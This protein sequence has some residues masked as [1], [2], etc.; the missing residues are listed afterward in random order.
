MARSRSLLKRNSS[1]VSLSSCVTEF[2]AVLNSLNSPFG[3]ARWER[4]PAAIRFAIVV[5]SDTGLTERAA[6]MR[7]RKNAMKIPA[8]RP[9]QAYRP[10]SSAECQTLASGMAAR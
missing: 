5:K 8:K 1:L 9:M 7:E 6:Q 2:S 4:S 10:S 3:C